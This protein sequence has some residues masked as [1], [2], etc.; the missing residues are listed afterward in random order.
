MQ[1][2]SAVHEC[3]APSQCKGITPEEIT[4]LDPNN[5]SH[6]REMCAPHSYGPLCGWCVEGSVLQNTGN[7]FACEGERNDVYSLARGWEAF[8]PRPPSA[9]SPR[10]SPVPR[11]TETRI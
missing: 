4:A 8:E 7:C 9:I 11:E 5:I 6:S 1:N 2:S 3:V 10:L